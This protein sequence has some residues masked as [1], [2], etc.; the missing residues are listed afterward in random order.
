[1]QTVEDNIGHIE[2][3]YVITWLLW[4]I[5]QHD[6]LRQYLIFKGGTVL[7]KAYFVDYR[8]S[9]YLDFTPI[10]E[11]DNKQI[12]A[13][14][15][16]VSIW[17]RKIPQFERLWNQYLAHQIA[18]LPDFDGVWRAINRYFKILDK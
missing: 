4:G 2:K 5:A 9:E 6:S 7:K 18:D 11:L 17:N 12:R 16:Q 15:N 10:T 13:A 14:F 3:D 1:M 8:F